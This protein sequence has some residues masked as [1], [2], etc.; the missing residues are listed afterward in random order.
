LKESEAH[1]KEEKIKKIQSAKGGI[2]G[3]NKKRN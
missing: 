2:R 1:L 3:N